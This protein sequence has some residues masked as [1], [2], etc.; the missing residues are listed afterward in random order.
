[1]FKEDEMGGAY[2]IH[3]GGVTSITTVA[4]EHNR[5]DHLGD[6]GSNWRLNVKVYEYHK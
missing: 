1:V 5:R 3:G 6:L 4:G 2:S